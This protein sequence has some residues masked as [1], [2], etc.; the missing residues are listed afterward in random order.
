[1]PL[2]HGSSKKAFSHNV[3]TEMDHGKPQKQAVA[4]AYNQA[5]EKK[6][7][8]GGKVCMACGGQVCK[9]DGGGPVDSSQG[10]APGSLNVNASD[11]SDFNKKF[12]SGSGFAKGGMIGR[13]KDPSKYDQGGSVQAS[14]SPSPSPDSDYLAKAKAISKGFNDATAMGSASA[15][16]N[17]YMGGMLGDPEDPSMM[18]E[19]GEVDDHNEDEEMLL[20]HCAREAM[21]AI[22]RK[23]HKAFHSSLQYMMAHALSKLTMDPSEE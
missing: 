7:A 8:G 5:G 15:S 4:I 17:K 21:D 14:P 3:K 22:D 20:D 9:Y 19:G 18:A 12:K 6:H 23:D 13:P 11:S 10:S 16:E 1:M 2:M